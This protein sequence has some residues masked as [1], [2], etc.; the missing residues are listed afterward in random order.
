MVAG[1]GNGSPLP[2]ASEAGCAL[3]RKVPAARKN[4]NAALDHELETERSALYEVI[5][6]LMQHR[7]LEVPT[8]SY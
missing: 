8:T 5:E 4:G 6:W 2:L 7:H 1:A 3:A